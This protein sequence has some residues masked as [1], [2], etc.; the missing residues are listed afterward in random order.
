MSYI[1]TDI[2]HIRDKFTWIKVYSLRQDPEIHELYLH[3]VL[4]QTY[5]CL[6]AP[7][8]RG[9]FNQ[10]A[11]IVSISDP[12][13]DEARKTMTPILNQAVGLIK[14]M[15]GLSRRYGQISFVGN[16]NG[17]IEV[18]GLDKG[19][20]VEKGGDNGLSGFALVILRAETESESIPFPWVKQ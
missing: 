17:S 5:Q 13:F 16:D 12:L 15:I 9:D 8:F 4:S 11:K 14:G 1:P 7:H 20:Y 18:F 2:D 10:P 3:L 6:I 19:R